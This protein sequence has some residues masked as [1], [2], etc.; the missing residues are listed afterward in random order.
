MS[1]CRRG[2]T[3]DL[4]VDVEKGE[5]EPLLSR[6]SSST[7]VQVANQNKRRRRSLSPDRGNRID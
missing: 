1:V 7:S 2:E 5:T 4:W 3:R 6:V